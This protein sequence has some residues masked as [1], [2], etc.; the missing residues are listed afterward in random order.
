MPDARPR[1]GLLAGVPPKVGALLLLLAALVAVSAAS[2]AYGARSVP[3]GTVA[4]VLLGGSAGT[5]AHVVWSVRVP[6]TVLGLL[7]GVALGMAGVV[8][9]GLTR[10]PLADPGLLGINAGAALAVVVAIRFAD[11]TSPAGYVWFSFAGAGLAAGLVYLFGSLGRAGPS[12]VRLVLAGAAMTA[13]LGSVTTGLLVLDASALN[14]VRFWLV[15][16]VAGRGTDVLAAVAPFV[17]AGAL[18]AVASGR[19]LDVLALGD[20]VA[21]GLGQR[22][23]VTRAMA[24]LTVVVLAGAATAAAGPIAF[25]GLAVP[26]VAR[27]ICGPRHAWVLA[28]TAVLA[29]LVLVA[30]DVV[31]RVAIRAQEL[32]VGVVVAVLGAPLFVALARRRTPVAP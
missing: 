13:F 28:F 21:R 26:H 29:P 8:V 23:G 2:V 22:V 1:A 17:A 7:V 6:R 30:S 19:R 27:M 32:E 11:V 5:D 25:V 4:D 31:G 15:G 24:A 10:N 14:H 12:P 20:D 18:L 3:L 9:Q 16:S